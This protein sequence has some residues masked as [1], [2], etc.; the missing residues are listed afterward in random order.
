MILMEKWGKNTKVYSLKDVYV[1]FL[2]IVLV[3]FLNKNLYF[4]Q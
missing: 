3:F 1:I 4:Y 2:D